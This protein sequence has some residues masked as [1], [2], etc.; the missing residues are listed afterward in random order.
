MRSV[1]RISECWGDSVRRQARRDAGF[2]EVIGLLAGMVTAMAG[3]LIGLLASL[4]H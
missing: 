1:D 2:R 3:V 4:P